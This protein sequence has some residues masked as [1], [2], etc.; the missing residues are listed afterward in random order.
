MVSGK[1]KIIALRT[2]LIDLAERCGQSGMMHSLDYFLALPYFGLQVPFKLLGRSR[3]I[4]NIITREREKFPRLFLRTGPHGLDAAVLLVEHRLH[5]LHT[6]LYMPTT[7]DGYRTVVAPPD[8]LDTVAK[9][10]GEFALQQ[11]AMMV[12]VSY[13]KP[14]EATSAENS[15][16]DFQNV[17]HLIAT[18]L[19]DASRVLPLASTYDATLA[20]MGRHTRRNFR[21]CQRRVV[22]ELGAVYIAE[23]EITLSEFLKVNEGSMY[24][25]PAWVARWRYES[26]HSMDQGVFAGLRAADGTWLSLIGG[27][28]EADTVRLDWQMNLMRFA[29]L[30]LV[31]AMRAFFIASQIDR[32]VRWIRFE[33]GTLHSMNSAFLKE[34][35]R[36]L[37]FA[38][39]ALPPGVVRRLSKAISTGGPLAKA[40]SSPALAWR[41]RPDQGAPHP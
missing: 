21:A 26:I 36:D 1:E 16:A 40:L 30:S 35:A 5:G 15:A 38:C 17:P 27:H 33:G 11:G 34:Q 23:P 4:S 9:E 31:S 29:S 37:I 7:V 39:R 20:R 13:L 8:Q 24:T 14:A 32:G 18:Q 22:Q 25:A 12:L 28:R 19:R 6:G 2:E 10:A 3:A 41:G